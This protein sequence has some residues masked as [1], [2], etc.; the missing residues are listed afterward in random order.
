M[1]LK[2]C[3][4][5]CGNNMLGKREE[6]F[7]CLADPGKY[8]EPNAVLRKDKEKFDKIVPWG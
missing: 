5:C 3:Y 4:S 2:D 7:I 6:T 1:F 8:M